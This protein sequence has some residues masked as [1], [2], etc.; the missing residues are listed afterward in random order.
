[1]AYLQLEPYLLLSIRFSS[2]FFSLSHVD[3]ATAPSRGDLA[4]AD[5]R[6]N[7]KS[8]VDPVSEPDGQW[9]LSIQFRQ[10]QLK[11]FELSNFEF[12]NQIE[13]LPSSV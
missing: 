3:I 6:A 7:L 4:P 12:Q 11:Q 13:S 10:F 8:V 1:V 9:P 2:V 5:D